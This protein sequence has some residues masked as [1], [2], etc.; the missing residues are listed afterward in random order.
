MQWSESIV[1]LLFKVAYHSVSIILSN[2]RS[3]ALMGINQI[4]EL[5]RNYDFAGETAIKFTS[6]LVHTNK[7]LYESKIFTKT[8]KAVQL[9]GCLSRT[10]SGY[11]ERSLCSEAGRRNRTLIMSKTFLIDKNSFIP[12]NM[13]FNFRFRK[14][15]KIVTIFSNLAKEH[16]K[17]SKCIIRK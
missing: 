5:F 4:H 17:L 11:F 3:T 7:Q 12:F 15:S 10:I 16:K 6:V 1:I 2:D 13:D 8:L 14:L 9:K